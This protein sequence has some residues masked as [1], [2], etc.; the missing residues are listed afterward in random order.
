MSSQKLNSLN[1]CVFT[2]APIH[3]LPN[4]QAE[5]GSGRFKPEYH[6]NAS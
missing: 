4:Q 2:I 1:H 3:P 5:L 6:Y